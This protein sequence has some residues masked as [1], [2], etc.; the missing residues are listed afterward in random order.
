MAIG[1]QNT[2]QTAKAPDSVDNAG[3]RWAR[4]RARS[5]TSTIAPART[6]SGPG[7]SPRV[8]CRS[9]N[10]PAASSVHHTS[11]ACS[12][13]VAR[14]TVSPSTPRV[15]AARTATSAAAS[16]P[17]SSWSRRRTSAMPSLITRRPGT[18]QDGRFPRDPSRANRAW[19]QRAA[20][21]AAEQCQRREE[22]ASFVDA[23]P[24][25]P[26]QSNVRRSRGARRQAN[27]TATLGSAP[28][29]RANRQPGLLPASGSRKVSEVV[30]FTGS[31]G[32]GAEHRGAV[33]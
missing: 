18:W 25:R 5:G 3:H 20:A 1:K 4:T 26:P 9:S 19:A 8:N 28:S 24:S 33:H 7:P 22:G 21:R 2:A 13:P 30:A 15:S 17:S 16:N 6:A 31:V 27:D 12:P 10:C 11:S 14:E 23:T 32:G 29:G